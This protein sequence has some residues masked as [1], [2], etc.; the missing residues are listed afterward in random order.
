LP[1]TPTLAN[2]AGQVLRVDNPASAEFAATTEPQP[3]ETTGDSL[4]NPSLL[5]SVDDV[6][7]EDWL[8]TQHPQTYTLQVLGAHDPLTLKTFLRHHALTDI[9]LFKTDY[10]D[11][12]WYVLLHGI[13]PDR[14]Q[15]MLALQALPSDLRQ[16][17]RPWPRTLASIQ[18]RIRKRLGLNTEKLS[19]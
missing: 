9:A 5:L 17:T 3:T 1:P 10:R 12:D 4:I 13:Y 2:N 8:L 18:A 14:S 11:R 15:A 6:K 19:D 7:G 16:A